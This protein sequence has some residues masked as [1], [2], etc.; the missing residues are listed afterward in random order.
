MKIFNVE[1]EYTSLAVLD[2]EGL[3]RNGALEIIEVRGMV[4]IRNM[5]FQKIPGYMC[6]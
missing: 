1:D 3:L 4:I 5:K 6:L 2:G